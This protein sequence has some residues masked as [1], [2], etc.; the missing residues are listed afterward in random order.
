MRIQKMKVFELLP[1]IC[2]RTAGFGAE[3][4]KNRQVRPMILLL[5]QAALPLYS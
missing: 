5:R 2:C 4:A 3:E 1:L